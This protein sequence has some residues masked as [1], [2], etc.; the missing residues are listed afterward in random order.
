MEYTPEEVDAL[1]KSKNRDFL[2]L[3]TQAGQIRDGVRRRDWPDQS[4]EAVTAYGMQIAT[5]LWVASVLDFPDIDES[6]MD[7]TQVKG[8]AARVVKDLFTHSGG[9]FDGL[10]AKPKSQDEAPPPGWR[11]LIL[12]SDTRLQGTETLMRPQDVYRADQKKR[13]LQWHL[14]QRERKRHQDNLLLSKSVYEPFSST[15]Q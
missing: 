4:V 6:K 3:W 12:Y 8:L 10:I 9:S 7:P 11:K 5:D 1:I 13:V 2:K 14:E 15:L